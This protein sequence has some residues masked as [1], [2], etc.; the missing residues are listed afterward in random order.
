MGSGERILVVEDEE[1][2]RE[3]TAALLDRLGYETLTAADGAAALEM[4]RKRDDVALVITDVVMPGVDGFELAERCRVLKPTLP[5]MLVSGH[6]LERRASSGSEQW[7]DVLLQKPFRR[8][9][10]ARFVARMLAGAVTP[11]PSR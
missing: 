2:V 3:L 9:E 6:P 5:V 7:L 11:G 1:S 4:L 10:L 8:E